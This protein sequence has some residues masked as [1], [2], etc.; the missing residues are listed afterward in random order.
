MADDPNRASFEEGF[1]QAFRSAKGNDAPL[2]APPEKWIP[3]PGRTALQTGILAGIE[4]AL[5]RRITPG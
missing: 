3:L 4:A 5:G 1:E 2:P